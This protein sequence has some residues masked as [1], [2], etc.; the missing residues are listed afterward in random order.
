MSFEK[1]DQIFFWSAFTERQINSTVKGTHT[2]S[3]LYAVPKILKLFHCT[4]SRFLCKLKFLL[5]CH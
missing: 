3:K 2:F 1:T 5:L 4:V